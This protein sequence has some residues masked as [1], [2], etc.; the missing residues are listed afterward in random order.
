MLRPDD[1]NAVNN[2]RALNF[3]NIPT[4]VDYDDDFLG[5]PRYNPMTIVRQKQGVDQPKNV[6]ELMRL[7]SLVTVSTQ[8]LKDKFQQIV[9]KVEVIRN[10]FDNYTY[11]LNTKRNDTR[12]VLWRGSKSH[13]RDL[14]HFK[15]VYINIIKANPD[16]DFMFWG[17]IDCPWLSELALSVDNIYFKQEVHHY[18][19]NLHLKELS[20]C[21]T[22]VPLEDTEFNHMK[23]DCAK[24]EAVSC[25]SL[26]IAP[27]WDE[28]N[29]NGVISNYLN[30]KD[31]I[32][33]TQLYIDGIRNKD[34]ELDSIHKLN[35]KYITDNRLLSEA[36]KI[37]LKLYKELVK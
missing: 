33:Q 36:N 32:L 10:A 12:L 34:K 30:E 28:W 22:L 5:C 24:L 14:F 19:Y 27:M 3:M 23:S 9:P 20:P 26:C 21:L 6:I 25:G 17:N 18:T 13:E 8:A 16:F 15:D 29:W 7:S 11:K 4:V 2:I 1:P 37:R 35:I 31:F